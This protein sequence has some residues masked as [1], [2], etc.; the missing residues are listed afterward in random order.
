[1]EREGQWPIPETEYRCTCTPVFQVP[2]GGRIGLGVRVLLG[3]C[4]TPVLIRWWFGVIGFTEGVWCSDVRA[5]SGVPSSSAMAVC[6]CAYPL[7][8]VTAAMGS[9]LTAGHFLKSAKSNQRRFAPTL[10]TSPRLGVP[11]LRLSIRGPPRWAIHGPARLTRR[12]AGL[13][14]DSSLRSASVFDG[15]PEIKIKSADQKTA[16]FVSEKD[17]RARSKAEQK[18]SKSRAKQAE[19]LS[20]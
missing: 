1:M 13:P 9:A 11:S 17:V 14:T 8:G 7:S 3:W 19:D 15:A 6:W 5:L 10:G 12:P 20:G 2:R 16:D 18:Q 4:I